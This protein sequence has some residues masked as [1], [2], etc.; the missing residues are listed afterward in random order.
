MTTA[1]ARELTAGI[2]NEVEDLSAV[3]KKMAILKPVVE[4]IALETFVDNT[5]QVDSLFDVVEE[6]VT[7]DIVTD[8][9]PRVISFPD[10]I[11]DDTSITTTFT[12]DAPVSPSGLLL[13]V[14]HAKS[15]R[16]KRKNVVVI[17][18]HEMYSYDFLEEM[19]A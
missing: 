10:Y 9:S 8:Y 7:D 15:A 11:I 16:V 3:F 5:V 14:N 6:I 12:T 13:F 19:A 18:E 2:K 17:N 1:L 4:Q